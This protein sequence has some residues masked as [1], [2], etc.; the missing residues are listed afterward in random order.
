VDMQSDL[1]FVLS[2]VLFGA[3]MST[4]A[5]T[6]Q[7]PTN[8]KVLF[9]SE[10]TAVPENIFANHVLIQASVEQRNALNNVVIDSGNQLAAFQPSSEAIDLSPPLLSPWNVLTIAISLIPIAWFKYKIHAELAAVQ[11]SE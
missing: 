10:Q 6:I 11:S 5:A 8:G 1:K 9:I 2:F 3:A 4:N 7:T